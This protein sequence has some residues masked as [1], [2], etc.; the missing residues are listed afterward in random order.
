MGQLQGEATDAS[1]MV[2]LALSFKIYIFSLFSSSVIAVN[3]LSTDEI[4]RAGRSSLKPDG[5]Q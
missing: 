4:L 5:Q 1:F 3:L 2:C